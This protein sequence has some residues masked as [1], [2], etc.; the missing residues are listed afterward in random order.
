MSDNVPVVYMWGRKPLYEGRITGDVVY[1][2]GLII[3]GKEIA[4]A[5]PPDM[6]ESSERSRELL[7]E[8]SKNYARKIKSA[9][10][11]K[12]KVVNGPWPRH[13]FPRYAEKAI[14]ETLEAEL[15]VEKPNSLE[16]KLAITSI[17]G[18]I[19]A[20]YFFSSNIT[21][22]AISNMTSTSANITGTVFFLVGLVGALFY[23]R[24]RK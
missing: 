19:G 18:I 4:S 22:F 7:V 12:V 17:I 1:E 5:N 8:W 10:Y 15:E 24:K 3:D 20:F 23:V 11:K 13:R 21:G 9:G 14:R 2:I 16:T 6:E